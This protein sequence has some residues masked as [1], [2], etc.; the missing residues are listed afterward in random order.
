MLNAAP[1]TVALSAQ[2]DLWQW[3]SQLCQCARHA[4]FGLLYMNWTLTE[5]RGQE[6]T[7]RSGRRLLF[8]A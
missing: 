5:T 2:L 8:H 1:N 7:G 4:D 3:S 6:D